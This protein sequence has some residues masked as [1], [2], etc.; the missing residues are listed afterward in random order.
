M[1]PLIV[2]QPVTTPSP[3]KR[4]LSVSKSVL[5][6]STNMSNSSNEFGIEQ[7]LDPLARRQLAAR[8][9][10][11]D[12]GFA[13]AQAGALRRRSSSS[14]RTCFMVEPA[15]NGVAAICGS[16]GAPVKP[17]PAL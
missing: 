17:L 14:W 2:P 1:R 3:G 8:V 7:E 6:C 13:A 4:F 10:R 12:A 11:L 5:R 9:L 16:Q 15:K